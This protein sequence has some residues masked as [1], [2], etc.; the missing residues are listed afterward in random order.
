MDRMVGGGLMAEACNTAIKGWSVSTRKPVQKGTVI[1][2]AAPLLVHQTLANREQVLVCASCH[3]FVGTPAT[4]L[5]MLEGLSRPTPSRAAAN[6]S[7]T[8]TSTKKRRRCEDAGLGPATPPGV[9]PASFRRIAIAGAP[10]SCLPDLPSLTKEATST[11]TATA[12]VAV[13]VEAEVGEKESEED[14]G[15]EDGVGGVWRCKGG[16]PCDDVYCSVRCREAALVGGHGLI[17]LGGS[18]PGSPLFEFHRYAVS[19]SETYLIAAAAVATAVSSRRPPSSPGGR[20]VDKDEGTRPFEELDGWDEPYVC[21]SHGSDSDAEEGAGNEVVSGRCKGRVTVKGIGFSIE[22]AEEAWS[23]LTAGLLYGRDGGSGGEGLDRGE[24]ALSLDFFL[25]LVRALGRHLAPIWV[26]SPLVSYCASLVQASPDAKARAL[27]W[28]A[29]AIERAGPFGGADGGGGGHG[30]VRWEGPYAAAEGCGLEFEGGRGDS[31]MQTEKGCAG[32]LGERALCRLVQALGAAAAGTATSPF[33]P[34]SV[35]GLLPPHCTPQHSCVPN[36]QLE[37]FLLPVT[38]GPAGNDGNESCAARS[39]GGGNGGGDRIVNGE[40]RASCNASKGRDSQTAL[41][42]GLVSLRSVLAGEELFAPYVALGQSVEDRRRELSSRFFPGRAAAELG[43]GGMAISPSPP[44]SSLP[45]QKQ[46]VCGC[47]R[48][49]FEAGGDHR[50]CGRE[51]LKVLADQALEEG[52]HGAALGLYR[53][54]LVAASSP[55]SGASGSVAGNGC[56]TLVLGE[57]NGEDSP[58]V[59]GAAA[60]AAGEGGG[61][62]EQLRA[63]EGDAR[64]EA[65]VIGAENGG[66]WTVGDALQGVGVALLAAGRFRDACRAWES[67]FR[68]APHH[69]ALR[70]QAEKEAAY[71]PRGK[72]S[73]NGTKEQQGK[74]EAEEGS[75]GPE[76]P[77]LQDRKEQRPTTALSS[78]IGGLPGATTSGDGGCAHHSFAS[79]PGGA[80]DIFLSRK[81]VLSSEECRAVIQAA[82]EYS[83]ANGGWTTSRHYAVPTTDLPV[84]VLKPVLPWFRSLVSERLFPA[85]AQQFDLAG[86]ARNVYVHDAFVVRYDEGKQ[87]HLPLHR[88][89]STHSFTIA[90]ND[91]KQYSGGGTF[92]PCL[93]R[94]LRPAEG[95]AL[96]FRGD[97]L[98]GGDPLLKGV[99]YII[100]CFCYYDDDGGADLGGGGG[101]G[102]AIGGALG[103][104]R[105]GVEESGTSSGGGGDVSGRGSGAERN[106]YAGGGK[107]DAG[108]GGR[109]IEFSS[110]EAFSFGFGFG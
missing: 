73:A 15:E 29:S 19:T 68:E 70:A 59:A 67:G 108:E 72:D 14:R 86:G 46:Q 32:L 57:E 7:A 4:Q 23:L 66:E 47:P 58:S 25:R 8:S 20:A 26:P 45:E 95:H 13:E 42:V 6:A 31:E 18:G 65:G 63:G 5:A 78:A 104:V 52:R 79:T 17:C 61:R 74:E 110:D 40:E 105:N 54:S 33:P 91:P 56:P 35:V 37:T 102:G 16:A 51:M 12:N 43:T 107:D 83:K 39:D 41:R 92:F 38:V 76:S 99:R 1:G 49:I 60:A 100:A 44:S 28:L 93:G 3:R 24:R 21:A 9:Y 84:H 48:C 82:E 2:G 50:S 87:R 96:S 62:K 90:L 75:E 36:V 64:A 71:R 89:Q 80:A 97:I 85:L 77:L 101:G 94:S 88:D 34:L 69:P 10:P 30:A 98:H 22:E 103:A 27:P 11:A 109:D 55:D 106:G 53:A 81:A